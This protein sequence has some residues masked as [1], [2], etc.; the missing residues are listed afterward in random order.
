MFLLERRWMRLGDELLGELATVGTVGSASARFWIRAE[1]PAPLELGLSSENV[2]VRVRFDARSSPEHDFTTAAS[3]P[4]DF[5]GAPPLSP[6]TEYRWTIRRRGGVLL[7]DGTFETAPENEDQAPSE[8]SF[9]IMSCHQPF[10][11]D[12]W[13]EAA[14]LR[15]LRASVDAF[16]EHGVKRVLMLG[17]QV[18]ADY[19]VRCSLFDLDWFHRVGPPGRASIFDCTTE[20]VRR[21][22]HHRYRAFWAMPEL[23][24]MLQ[25]R[26]MTMM[27]D[28]H[29]LVDNFG[30]RREHTGPCW[31]SV[32]EGALLAGFDYQGLRTH[33]RTN[34]RPCS[35][36]YVIEHGPVAMFVMDLR[37]ERGWFDGRRQ[38]YGEQQQRD[39]EAFLA[40]NRKRPVLLLA[41]SVPL[42]HVPEWMPKVASR[43]L[44]EA[45]DFEDRW[46]APGARPERDRL[47][48]TICNHRRSC[49]D[50]KLVLPSGDI[51]VGLVS[52]IEW[53]DDSCAPCHQ[54]VSS[55][56]SNIE[57]PLIQM[58]ASLVTR[59]R[60][61]LTS[62]RVSDANIELL[63]RR[64]M[65]NPY[66]RLN[67]G[68]VKVTRERGGWSVRLLLIGQ[69][70]GDPPRPRTV[71]ESEPI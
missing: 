11:H 57:Q 66:D 49:P 18:Y 41:L 63:D 47:V 25:Q 12:G 43:M 52:R 13:L 62:S 21:L 35:L 30:T 54:L 59:M 28:D 67:I 32:R 10:D 56:V 26:P 16:E 50:Q 51:H 34:G 45:N 48:R 65:K 64:G 39:L 38:V 31:R 15:M 40:A 27:I 69:D 24:R 19:P 37:S 1:A 29:D 22:Y 70:D 17:D 4:H 33:A 68:L 23:K 53:D 61:R 55:A 14:R 60:H 2:E 71:F 36:H 20:E 44:S 8:L 6:A 7:G 58:G 5:E 3:Y 42:V 9:A 46:E